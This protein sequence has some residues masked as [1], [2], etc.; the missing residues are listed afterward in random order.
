MTDTGTVVN[1]CKPYIVPRVEYYEYLNSSFL[2]QLCPFR[3]DY[4]HLLC[5]C[6][7]NKFQ[8]MPLITLATSDFEY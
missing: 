3:N 8:G 2:R 5:N 6:K 7:G 4:S 1:A